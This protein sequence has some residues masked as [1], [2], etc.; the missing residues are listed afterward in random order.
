LLTAVGLHQW[1]K[2]YRA[3]CSKVLWKQMHYKSLEEWKGFVQAQGF[4]V[5]EGFSYDSRKICLMNDFFYPFSLFS[6]IVKKITNRWVLFPCFRSILI[7]P[8]F[9]LLKGVL[10]KDIR[11]EDGGLV[12]L[13]LKKAGPC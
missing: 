9:Q 11:A 6:V 5:V 3:F 12:F 13:S 1:A 8:L 2:G 4:K 7:Y 10:N